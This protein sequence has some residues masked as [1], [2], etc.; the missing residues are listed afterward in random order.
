MALF[1]AMASGCGG[2][3]SAPAARPQP[4]SLGALVTLTPADSTLLEVARPAELFASDATRRV[5]SAVLPP[6]Q[7]DSFAERT[8][9]DPRELTELVFAE[10]PAGRVVLARGPFDA[11]FA[12]REAGERMAPIESS[13]ERPVRRVGLL[14]ERRVDLAA[15]DDG[16]VSWVEGTPQLAAAVLAAARRP[17]ERREHPLRGTLLRDLRRGAGRAPLVVY[18]PQPLGLPLDSGVGVLLARERALAATMRPTDAGALDVGADMRGEFPP[19][20]QDNFRAL[21]RSLAESDLGAALGA[22]DA[23]HTLRITAEE[24]RVALHAELD[25]GLLASG[26]RALF[27]AELRELLAPVVDDPRSSDA[28]DSDSE[29]VDVTVPSASRPDADAE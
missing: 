14:G 24:T 20:A 15:L 1:A 26:L 25:P 27:V 9:V 4:R 12:V 19:G 23:L 16:V 21:A 5:V 2:A 7:L 8:G 11:A 28:A 6:E 17:P 10:T 22:R 18:A 3:A 29:R 13:A